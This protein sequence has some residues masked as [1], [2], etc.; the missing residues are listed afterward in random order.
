MQNELRKT[1]DAE[2]WSIIASLEPSSVGCALCPCTENPDTEDKTEE[3]G[4]IQDPNSKIGKWLVRSIVDP[5]PITHPMIFKIDESRPLYQ[6]F[7]AHGWSEIVIETRD[8]L[9]ELHELTIDEIKAVLQLYINRVI[10]LNKKEQVEQVCIAK[11]NLKHDFNHSYSRIFTL[12]VIPKKMKEKLQSFSD[13]QIK[14][15]SCIYCDLIREEK[16]SPRFIF[17]NEHFICTTPFSQTLDYETW[18]M[19]KKHTSCI[20]ELNE[21]E[22]FSLAEVIKNIMMRLSAAIKPLRYGMCFYIKP[23]NEK[24]FHFHV[25]I[26]QKSVRSSIDE[27]Y[28]LS[29]NK[30]SPEDVSKILRGKS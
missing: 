21:F 29:L 22:I 24:D 6:S 15:E 2:A 9:K 26:N 20:S 10:D 17:E 16:N 5:Y 27:G 3:T 13:Y 19:P 30:V 8:H 25:V 28:G 1:S 12:P 7:K 14:N 11:D 18:I 4:S 23:K